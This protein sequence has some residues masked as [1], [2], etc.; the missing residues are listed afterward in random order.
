MMIN[1]A[2][3]AL[4][5][6][7][8]VLACASLA[9]AQDSD[10]AYFEPVL[11]EPPAAPSGNGGIFQ[12]SAGYTGLYEGTRASKVGDLVTIL[13]VESTVTAKSVRSNNDRSG[14]IGLAPPLT[15][16]FAFLSPDDLNASGGAS[17]NGRGSAGQSSSLATSLTVTI[18]E[19]RPNGTAL[20]QGEKRML[21]SQGDEWVRFRG[22]I[23]LADV[24]AENT[25]V[26]SR[27]ADSYIEYSGK[28]ALQ[29]A[30]RPGWLSRFFSVISPF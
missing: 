29:R 19:V 18:A 1:R 20:V 16:P 13:L 22:I 6:T 28:G 5:C 7:V 30:S 3:F 12:S 15:G 9:Q 26:S 10:D 4:L 11:P 27:V 24:D 2:T 25:V 8:P 14:S 21:L 23:R 17:F